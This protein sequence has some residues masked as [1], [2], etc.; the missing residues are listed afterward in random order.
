MAASVNIDAPEQVDLPHRFADVPGRHAFPHAAISRKEQVVYQVDTSRQ[1]DIVFNLDATSVP[2]SGVTLRLALEIQCL[3]VWRE[4]SLHDFPDCSAKTSQ[5]RMLLHACRV[6]I[7]IGAMSILSITRVQADEASSAGK[8]FRFANVQLTV[9]SVQTT[10]PWQP[11]RFAIY[12]IS[13]N[14]H[15]PR[16]AAATVP[17]VAVAKTISGLQAERERAAPTAETAHSREL[18]TKREASKRAA[19]AVYENEY[20]DAAAAVRAFDGA[21]VKLARQELSALRRAAQTETDNG[22]GGTAARE[23][24]HEGEE[25]IEYA[26]DDDEEEEEEKENDTQTVDADVDVSARLD[27]LRIESVKAC[28]SGTPYDKSRRVDEVNVL[29]TNA[30]EIANGL[31]GKGVDLSR[32]ERTMFKFENRRF[33]PV[34]YALEGVVDNHLTLAHACVAGSKQVNP[35]D[36]DA[37]MSV[38][39]E[40]ILSIGRRPQAELERLEAERELVAPR[41]QLLDARQAV[42]LEWIDEQMRDA[43]LQLRERATQRP[44]VASILASAAEA[45]DKSMEIVEGAGASHDCRSLHAIAT[46]GDSPPVVAALQSA[47]PAP[48]LALH[49][50]A[51]VRLSRQMYQDM[52]SD[53]KSF[54]DYSRLNVGFLHGTLD[55]SDIVAIKRAASSLHGL[56]AACKRPPRGLP[57]HAVS[58]AVTPQPLETGGVGH[59]PEGDAVSIPNGMNW[60]VIPSIGL[61]TGGDSESDRSRLVPVKQSVVLIPDALLHMPTGLLLQF[62][63]ETTPLP[64]RLFGTADLASAALPNV[65]LMLETIHTALTTQLPLQGRATCPF[66]SGGSLSE[67]VLRALAYNVRD[68]TLLL[69]GQ[70]I[71]PRCADAAPAAKRSS[72][73]V[74]LDPNESGV[75]GV[76][77]GSFAAV[78]SFRLTLE[79]GSTHTF[80][81]RYPECAVEWV[82]EAGCWKAYSDEMQYN[83]AFSKAR[84]ELRRLQA[85]DQAQQARR[86]AQQDADIWSGVRRQLCTLVAGSDADAPELKALRRAATEL[87]SV[88]V[89]GGEMRSRKRYGCTTIADDSR[90]TTS[91]SNANAQTAADVHLRCEDLEAPG[92]DHL[93]AVSVLKSIAFHAVQDGRM[94]AVQHIKYH[95]LGRKMFIPIHAFEDLVL[96]TKTVAAAIDIFSDPARLQEQKA[97]PVKRAGKAPK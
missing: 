4:A 45:L 60:H 49:W 27:E 83:N 73:T 52:V 55:A 50:R 86:D 10:P 43:E 38:L 54:T 68:A 78:W 11:L 91:S 53:A 18:Q 15:S 35:R 90:C 22:T 9:L 6:G 40:R 23:D 62:I 25:E 26:D 34:S 59:A 36:V 57:G 30:I 64:G 1:T 82:S 31:N 56:A 63:A 46:L 84:S 8:A 47:S 92:V 41:G 42:Q 79:S 95:R 5:K 70:P 44:T 21:S 29:F 96:V 72:A 32:I 37:A 51:F 28:M 24:A 88:Q 76:Y 93:K 66:R 16:I 94:L 77:T 7:G 58:L 48:Q 97:W 87:V 69:R 33:A 74:E 81:V 14:T 20:P 3:G 65:L 17:F 2:D 75:F 13:E 80:A 85:T 67:S 61:L 71:P 39:R 89:E 12:D 19:R